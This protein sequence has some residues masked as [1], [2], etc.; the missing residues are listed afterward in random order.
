MAEAATKMVRL[1]PTTHARLAE[2]AALKQQSFADTLAG[3]V[4]AALSDCLLDAHNAA[5]ERLTAD[6]RAEET[7]ELQAWDVALADGLED[8]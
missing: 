5:Y 8:E 1:D 3:L 4:E 2:L 7:R 6:E